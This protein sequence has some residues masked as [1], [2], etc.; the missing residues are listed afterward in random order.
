MLTPVINGII[1][2]IIISICSYGAV[3]FMLIKIGMQHNF[4]KGLLF[5][6]GH[7]ASILLLI[8]VIQ[9]S[10]ISMD[11]FTPYK[12]MFCLIGGIVVL[13]FGVN[14]YRIAKKYLM[15]DTPVKAVRGY[16]YFVEG[17][18]LNIINPFEFILWFGVIGGVNMNYSFSGNQSLVFSLTAVVFMGITDMGKVLLGRQISKFLTPHNLVLMNRIVGVLIMGFGIF[19]IACYFW[20]SDQKSELLGI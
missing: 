5:E 3:F 2:G 14:S 7:I 9:F 20:M 11:D 16:R 19:M 8:T 1:T 10:L 4:R 17:F 13:G 18:L 15:T 12:K 6:L